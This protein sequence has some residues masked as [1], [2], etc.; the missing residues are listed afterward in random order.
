MH[1]AEGLLDLTVLVPLWIFTIAYGAVAVNKSRKTINEKQLPIIAVIT[2]MVFAFQ[3]LNF[4]I[5]AGTSGHLLGFI[6]MAILISPSASFLMISVVLIVQ[7]FT[8]ADGGIIAL[9]GNIF[10]MGIATLP[11][12]FVYWIIRKKLPPKSTEGEKFDR[13]LIIGA[14]TGAYISMIVAS[15]ICGIEIGV[16]TGFPYGVEFTIPTMV[17]YHA[18]IGI[19]E[20]L[21]TMMVILFFYKYAP[22]YIPSMEETPIWS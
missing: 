7:A 12:Y 18:L 15:F 3:M 4:P 14:F 6:L 21:I 8:F 1:I 17:G 13:G 5:L 19:G 10:N 20:G 11:G 16:S 9:G 22:E 2:A